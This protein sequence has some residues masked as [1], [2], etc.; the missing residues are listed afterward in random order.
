MGVF[1]GTKWT[2]TAPNGTITGRRGAGIASYMNSLVVFGGSCGGTVVDNVVYRL[3][4]D[5]LVWTADPVNTSSMLAPNVSDASVFVIDNTLFVVGGS[6]QRGLEAQAYMYDLVSRTWSTVNTP[7][8]GLPSRSK[9]TFVSLINRVYFYGGETDSG[10]ILSDAY[11]FVL[12]N[13]CF[14]YR[15][16]EDCSTLAPNS[17]CGWCD[18]NNDGYRCLAGTAS[19]AP[20]VSASCND[21][22]SYVTDI[23]FCPQA[24]PSYAIA[25]LVIG[26]VVVVGVIIFAI[27]KV[28]SGDGKQEYERIS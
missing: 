17:G 20:Y 25:L 1:D 24:F 18:K 6:P 11:Q 13:K 19:T 4:L 5:T 9:A 10:T 7:D 28:R 23:D 22:K 14:G 12:E 3:A 26:G 8:S 2:V 15:S 21:T 16:C 27:M